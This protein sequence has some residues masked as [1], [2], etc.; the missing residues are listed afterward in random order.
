MTKRRRLPRLASRQ[1][2]LLPRRKRLLLPHCRKRI[3]L[4]RRK[5]LDLPYRRKRLDLPHRRHPLLLLEHR[6][7]NVYSLLQRRCSRVRP[8][9][10]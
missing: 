2:L 6:N 1:G 10:V 5:R 8:Y 4:P 9:V 3:F 7:R